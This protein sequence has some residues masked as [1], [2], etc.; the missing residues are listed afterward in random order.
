MSESYIKAEIVR[1]KLSTMDTFGQLFGSLVGL[2]IRV[3]IVWWFFAAWFPEL[4]LTYWQ[5]VLPIYAVRVLILKGPLG[6]ALK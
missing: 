3:L 5:L 4:G 1:P 2:G 6:R